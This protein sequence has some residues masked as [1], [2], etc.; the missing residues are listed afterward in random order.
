MKTLHGRVKALRAVKTLT[1]G[2]SAKR[3]ESPCLLDFFTPD[4][5]FIQFPDFWV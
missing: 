3:G 1:G 2:E 5:F 4:L